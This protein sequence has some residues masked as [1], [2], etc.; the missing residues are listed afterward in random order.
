MASATYQGD[1]TKAPGSWNAKVY[2][3]KAGILKVV[4]TDMGVLD[5]LLTNTAQSGHVSEPM[6]K[7]SERII[8][9]DDSGW[10][11]AIMGVL[12]GAHDSQ[13]RS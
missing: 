10:G 11:F 2:R 13:A 8:T 9:I 6:E 3:N 5:A 4:T 7:K 1:D 12:I